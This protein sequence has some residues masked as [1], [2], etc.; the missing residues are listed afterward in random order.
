MLQCCMASLTAESRGKA[1]PCNQIAFSYVSLFFLTSPEYLQFRRIVAI[2]HALA[3]L[4]DLAKSSIR[5]QTARN[6]YRCVLSAHVSRQSQG[7]QQRCRHHSIS[8]RGWEDGR[9]RRMTGASNVARFI[10]TAVRFS[11]S[12]APDLVFTRCTP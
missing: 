1:K 6:R 9:L 8:P 11:E 4:D 5:R 3:G 12:Q 7:K 2:R 10:L